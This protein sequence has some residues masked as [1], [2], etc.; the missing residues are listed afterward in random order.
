M[1]FSERFRAHSVKIATTGIMA[2]GA[3]SLTGCVGIMPNS[4]TQAGQQKITE[5]H[6]VVYTVKAPFGSKITYTNGKETLTGTANNLGEWTKTVDVKGI[7]SVAVTVVSEDSNQTAT[8]LITVDGTQVSTGMSG[9]GT[10]NSAV[11]K[12]STSKT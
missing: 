5:S 12:G 9:V 10:D 11:C 7:T 6:S 1:S 8:C 3:V 4:N 2:L